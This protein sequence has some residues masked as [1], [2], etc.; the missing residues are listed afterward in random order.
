MTASPKADNLPLP[1]L[2]R[3]ADGN[4]QRFGTIAVD[5]P[6]HFR[7]RAPSQNPEIS[8]NP[9]RHYPTMDL[10]HAEQ[11]PIRQLAKSDCWVM[12]WI[13]GPLMVLGVHNRLF[14]AWGVRP[15]STLFVWIKTWNN[16]DTSTLARSPLL[17]QDLAMGT[18]FTTR[19][20]AEFV[21]LGR[22]GSP[23]VGRRD[24]R[25]V[26]VSNRAE[27]SRKP[28]E[29]FRRAWFFGG[30]DKGGPY[31]DMFAGE[32][33]PDWTSFGWSHREGERIHSSLQTTGRRARCNTCGKPAQVNDADVCQPCMEAVTQ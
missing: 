29:F 27:H 32:E 3:D 17:E 13:T 31:L 19:Q 25:Q 22:I 28:V 4:V 7:S 8:R 30:G 11:L 18:G 2:P 33:R 14:R 5:I 21:M 1:E 20:N 23:H 15:S 24:I 26:I 6:W 12:L 9:Q 16:F 10:E